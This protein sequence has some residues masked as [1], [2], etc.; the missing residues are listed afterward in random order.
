MLIACIRAGKQNV[1]VRVKRNADG[2]YQKK[3]KEKDEKFR[4]IAA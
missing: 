1:A 4:Y 3:K 2:K